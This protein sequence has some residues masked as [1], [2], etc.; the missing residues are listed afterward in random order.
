MTDTTQTCTP[1]RHPWVPQGE[2]RIVHDVQT[3]QP[4]GCELDVLCT[5]CRLTAVSSW[6]LP[7]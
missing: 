4:I 3:G 5:A 2:T 1:D 6:D 7:R